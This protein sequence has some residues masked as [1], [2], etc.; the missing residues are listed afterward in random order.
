MRE[1]QARIVASTFVVSANLPDRSQTPTQKSSIA[2]L[3][4]RLVGNPA[5][6]FLVRNRWEL[7]LRSRGHWLDRNGNNFGEFS[8][9]HTQWQLVSAESLAVDLLGH[10]FSGAF[11]CRGQPG[12]GVAQN[13]AE[14]P[15][16]LAT[17]STVLQPGNLLWSLSQSFRDHQVL[18]T[19]SESE[20]HDR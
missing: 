3:S 5:F 6:H 11:Q 8:L 15:N 16:V 14:A 2:V 17:A 9:Q 7:F 10:C 19:I 20:S 1:S 18:L 13:T 4:S 12:A